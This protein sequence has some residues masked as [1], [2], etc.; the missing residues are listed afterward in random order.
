MAWRRLPRLCPQG[1]ARPGPRLSGQHPCLPALWASGSPAWP[2]RAAVK[3]RGVI[4]AG[5]S[6]LWLPDGVALANSK[7]LR[8]R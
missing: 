6:E 2:R 8:C 7:S 4:Q 5:P 3:M 1:S